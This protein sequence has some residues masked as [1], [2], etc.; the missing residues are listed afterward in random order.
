MHPNPANEVVSITVDGVDQFTYTI[1]K[2]FQGKCLLSGMAQSDDLV[3]ISQLNGGVYVFEIA[4]N[5]K[6]QV[7]KLVV[8]K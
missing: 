7:V 4:A 1:F 6:N 3:S 5:G 2:I 8:T